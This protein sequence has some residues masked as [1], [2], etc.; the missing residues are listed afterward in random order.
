MAALPGS[1]WLEAEEAGADRKK[2]GDRHRVQIRT[3]FAAL[4]ERI[5]SAQK[6]ASIC[7]YYLSIVR[8]Y[9]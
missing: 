1:T 7:F 3:G 8:A 2:T 9:I 5:I 6:S 4:D